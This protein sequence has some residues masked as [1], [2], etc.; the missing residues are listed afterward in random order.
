M[1]P[2]M[3]GGVAG[4]LLAL[5]SSQVLAQ[6]LAEIARQEKL[7]RESLAEKATA[8]GT[9]PKVY[10]IADLRGGSRL[11]TSAAETPRPAASP[12][13]TDATPPGQDAPETAGAPMDEEGWQNRINAVRQ[14]RDRAQL[15]VAALQNR[16]D[17]LLAEFTGR[18]DPAQRSVIE[19]D[20]LTGP[21]LRSS[22][23]TRPSATS[24]RKPGAPVCHPGGSVS[25]RRRDRRVLAYDLDEPAPD[26]TGSRPGPS[27]GRDHPTPTPAPV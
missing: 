18:D 14:A 23:S 17:G 13:G 19:Q 25:G 2:V 15:M 10:S 24:R 8:E 21:T 11:T 27:A 1:K 5:C 16:A 7:R 6:S 12:A 9:A 20:R 3:L 26:L 4:L 22:N